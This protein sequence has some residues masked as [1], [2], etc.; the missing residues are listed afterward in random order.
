[1]ERRERIGLGAGSLLGWAC[2][3]LPETLALRCSFRAA[4]TG[5]LF[6][7][8]AALVALTPPAV[9]AGAYE[10]ARVGEDYDATDGDV[11][12]SRVYENGVDINVVNAGGSVSYVFVVPKGHYSA[13]TLAVF[14][15]HIPDQFLET[16]R[17]VLMDN[18]ELEKSLITQDYESRGMLGSDLLLAELAALK[19]RLQLELERLAQ[20]YPPPLG[21]SVALSNNLTGGEDVLGRASVDET[22]N[23]FTLA[24]VEPY[25]DTGSNA[26][27]LTLTDP[28]SGYA[29]RDVSLSAE[30]GQLLPTAVSVRRIWGPT[31]TD[32]ANAISQLGWPAVGPKTVI[33]AT[34][35]HFTDALAG[36]PLAKYVAHRDGLPAPILLTDP[37]RLTNETRAEII[38]VG[39][40]NVYL[41]GGPGALNASVQGELGA[42]PSV[43][44]VE[45]L[46]GQTA[47]GTALAIKAE[48]AA[49]A[50]TFS[51]PPPTTAIVAS[52]EDFPDA[53]AVSGA[54]A[55]NNMPILL[56]KPFKREP[57]PE[58]QLA[59]L[60]V[61]DVII[62]GG[63]GAVHPDLEAWL[64]R[65]GTNIIRRYWGQDQYDTAVDIASSGFDVFGFDRSNVFVSRGDH[66]ADGLA[67]GGFAATLGPA[68][69]V[70]V[71]PDSIPQATRLWLGGY[72]SHFEKIHL[73]GGHGAISDS[74]LA[75][76]QEIAK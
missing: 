38:R 76:I 40:E 71:E 74:L 44:K 11:R 54:A 1:M 41:V 75:E 36:G 5:L 8:L 14:G 10:N 22:L 27:V 68:P 17:T 19:D 35:K 24:T 48:M 26:V 20:R 43:K 4:T 46:W 60:G 18:Y 56:V 64:V 30:Y 72:R 57:E 62:V 53:L 29:V 66:F 32:T 58:T 49:L 21:V 16:E 42:I 61:T 70:L 59:L 25:V 45:R 39:A 13:L 7:V 12:A 67:A 37:A 28:Y 15:Q 65:S 34:N 33:V 9:R 73:L 50:Q 51:G 31:A 47:Y 55:A 63:P 52:G 23:V 69:L 3:L 6:F 2:S